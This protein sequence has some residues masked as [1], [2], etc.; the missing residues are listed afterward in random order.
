MIKN[1]TF[2]IL[3]VFFLCNCSRHD[4][5]PGLPTCKL[6]NIVENFS[7]N[8]TLRIEFEYSNNKL[9]K[10]ILYGLP[11]G[12]RMGYREY[13]YSPGEV[14]KKAY[15]NDSTLVYVDTYKVN[16]NN[17]VVLYT[18]IN[19]SDGY[20]DIF[21]TTRYTYDANNYLIS[22]DYDQWYININPSYNSHYESSSTYSY[23]SSHL[24]EITTVWNS[25]PAT[26]RTIE[27]YTNLNPNP[28]SFSYSPYFMGKTDHMLIKK[29]GDSEYT[30]LFDIN[31][32]V[33]ERKTSQNNQ[34]ITIDKYQYDC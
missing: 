4:V 27:Y 7:G 19:Y 29:E 12:K 26:V 21:D 14:I 1:T 32:N 18:C 3:A 2:F 24:C 30:Y 10:E 11:S 17:D 22:I 5:N 15:S 8:D 33:I 28:N 31:R 25:Q 6:E 20:K 23:P 13:L 34:I 16:S 9:S